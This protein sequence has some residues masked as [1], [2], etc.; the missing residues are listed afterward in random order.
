MANSTVSKIWPLLKTTFNGFNDNNS[1][2]L[3]AALAFN[4]IFSIPPLLVII[5]QAAGFFLGE[6][7]VSGELSEQIS[8]AI[9]PNAAES[10][11]SIIQ[12]A[13][14]SDAGGI[15]FWIGIGTLIFASTTFFATL[16]QSLNTVWNLKPKPTNGIVKMLQVR[17][18]SFGI[19]LSM[20]FLMLLS[21]L[22][23]TIIAFLSDY[24][25][26][27][28]P[29]VSVFFISVVDITISISI[30][31]ILFALIFK[32]LPDAVIRWRDVWVGALITALLF[33][34]GKY[35]ISWFIGTSDPG[36]AYGAAGSIIVILV[37]IYYTSAIVLFG[38]EFTQQYATVFGHNIM[39]KA[40]AVF[41]KEQE[42][43]EHPKFEKHKQGTGR[44]RAEGRFNQEE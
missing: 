11:E 34:L 1:L 12:N 33:V 16:Q 15:A 21:L 26:S 25:T 30:V 14:I 4:A 2:L 44:P 13:A 20:A 32:F 6:K 7:A 41:Y 38:A 3:A 37:W 36:S 42:I 22:V 35:L 29:E 43:V 9:G 27:A 40:H 10:I 8:S 18:F 39:P 31:T 19:V 24:I 17:L 28:F 23:S 5:I